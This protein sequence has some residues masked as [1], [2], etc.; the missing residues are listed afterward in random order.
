MDARQRRHLEAN[1]ARSLGDYRT[2]PSEIQH[3]AETGS[4]RLRRFGSRQTRT[5]RHHVLD[6][7]SSAIPRRLGFLL[8]DVAERIW[9]PGV[10]YARELPRPEIRLGAQRP[11]RFLEQRP[12]L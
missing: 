3:A 6:G 12:S 8:Q 1:S 11:H 2:K 9:Y 10:E 7:R 5:P 4:A